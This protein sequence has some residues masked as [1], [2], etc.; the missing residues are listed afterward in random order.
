MKIFFK[1]FIMEESRIYQI[2]EDTFFEHEKCELTEIEYLDFIA[3]FFAIKKGSPYR[4][5]FRVKWVSR[6]FDEPIS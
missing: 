4:E 6:I 1:A 2:M 5:I 3:P